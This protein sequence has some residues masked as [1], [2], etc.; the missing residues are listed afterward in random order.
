MAGD[1][2]T[3]DV[4]I[5]L[6]ESSLDKVNADLRREI[7]ETLT[8]VNEKVI[9]STEAVTESGKET[10][11]VFEELLDI[12]EA[13]AQSTNTSATN[14]EGLRN[15]I[16]YIGNSTYSM[17]G[18]PVAV[19]ESDTER[20]NYEGTNREAKK[21]TDTE[22]ELEKQHQEEQRRNIAKLTSAMQTTQHV[23]QQGF[24]MGTGLLKGSLG[25]LEDIYG[26]MKAASPLLQAVESL[27]QTA[28]TL[29]F[30][31]LGN[32]LG[33]LLI[34]AVIELVDN[35]V[36]M[37]DLF[38]DK[39]LGEIFGIAIE[40]GADYLSGF[41]SS[42]AESLK[43]QGGTLGSIA[44]LIE[45]VANVSKNLPDIINTILDVMRFI[46]THIDEI[47]GLLIA[48]Y[49]LQYTMGIAQMMVT[50]AANTEVMGTSVGTIGAWGIIGSAMISGGAGL[51]ADKF[52]EE[53]MGD[54]GYV[55]PKEGGSLRVLAER[56]EGEYVIPESKI[57]HVGGSVT[58]NNNFY[59][60]NESELME[61]V[62]DT[63][64]TAVSR[65]R[66]S[67]AF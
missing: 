9:N 30:L 44:D 19:S 51:A 63:V 34:P 8:R 16:D 49:T 64:N 5:E 46:Y 21:R 26:R 60:Y 2:I 35:V 17:D 28:M 61:K 23:A 56:G 37:W 12:A 1:R 33:E 27:F 24:S 43:D 50:V 20:Y 10:V 38:E 48:L 67:G 25:L 59:G 62:N 52:V 22:K 39:T 57:G 55:P 4:D 15:S 65:S 45:V 54:G 3:V 13:F 53:F 42:M 6:T 14:L 41:F 29:F 58:I 40:K 7:T 36:G 11:E 31:P 47:T 18:F 32:K 66:I